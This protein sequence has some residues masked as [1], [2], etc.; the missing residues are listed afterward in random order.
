MARP[1]TKCVQESWQPKGEDYQRKRRIALRGSRVDGPRNGTPCSTLALLSWSQN[2]HNSICKGGQT[3]CAC[4]SCC[5]WSWDPSPT[6][7]LQDHPTHL[8]LDFSLGPG[9]GS[10]QTL[11]LLL[12][13]HL[14]FLFPESVWQ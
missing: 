7:A 14:G 13:L 2:S 3:L 10:L 9:L 6:V 8:F 4:Q 1:V 12:L 5:T 11:F